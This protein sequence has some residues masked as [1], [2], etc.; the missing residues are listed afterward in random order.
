[1]EDDE[2]TTSDAKVKIQVL[3]MM[4]KLV[5]RLPKHQEELWELFG[6][7]EAF[8][9]SF[10]IVHA[11]RDSLMLVGKSPQAQQLLEYMA[12]SAC[13][14]GPFEPWKIKSSRPQDRFV[15]HWVDHLEAQAS[16]EWFW[17]SDYPPIPSVEWYPRMSREAKWQQTL[18]TLRSTMMSAIPNMML[19]RPVPPNTGDWKQATKA[20][21]RREKLGYVPAREKAQ[22][23]RARRAP[24]RGQAHGGWKKNF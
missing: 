3:R 4:E 20:G 12:E 15:G 19:A 9:H 5:L 10:D 17:S 14:E 22:Q 7:E 16:Y 1:M 18:D 21:A 2:R 11:D 23:A 8:F 13:E 6:N 24:R